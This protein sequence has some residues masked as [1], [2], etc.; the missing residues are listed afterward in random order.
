MMLEEIMG[1]AMADDRGD[2]GGILLL[3]GLLR[4]EAPWLYEFLMEI[5]RAVRSGN[6]KIAESE[7]SRLRRFSE[8]AMRGPLGEE[9]GFRNKEGFILFMEVPR[10]VDRLVRRAFR[11][12][13]S[14]KP[15]V[16]PRLRSE[17]S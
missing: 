15:T 13:E 9:L 3:A 16:A 2:P 8:L 14:E 4:D 12:L 5:Y 6:Q 17:K 7:I 10:M 1:M 11:E